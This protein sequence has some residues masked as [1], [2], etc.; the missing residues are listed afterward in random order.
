MIPQFDI[1]PLTAAR[2][3]VQRLEATLNQAKSDLDRETASLK[4]NVAWNGTECLPPA[5]EPELPQLPGFLTYGT[6]LTHAHTVCY[7]RLTKDAGQEP[8][9][10]ALVTLAKDEIE[11]TKVANGQ[12]LSWAESAR[13][14]TV[15]LGRSSA[16][17]DI[18]RAYEACVRT[19]MRG[20]TTDLVSNHE[21]YVAQLREAHFRDFNGCKNNR[22]KVGEYINSLATIESNLEDLRKKLNL[23]ETEFANQI[24]ENSL[25]EAACSF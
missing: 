19:V 16:K 23:L 13:G 1:A 6:I 14:E 3:E 7:E 15:I 10:E 8:V 5:K 11:T 4:I 12:N 2:A 18:H 17:E 20:C 24:K 25:I 21:A 22:E 9:R